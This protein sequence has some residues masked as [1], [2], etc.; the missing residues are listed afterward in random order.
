MTEQNE[1]LRHTGIWPFNLF[2]SIRN[3]SDPAINNVKI[4]DPVAL[5]FN[6]GGRLIEAGWVGLELMPTAF[7][8]RVVDAK[9]DDI[10]ALVS[11]WVGDHQAAIADIFEERLREYS[12]DDL[13]KR[14]M[15][16][17]LHAY[18]ASHFLSTVRTLM[19]EFERFGRMVARAD[20]SLPRNQKEAVTA[21]QGY[22]GE[23]PAGHYPPIE[24]LSTYHM[25]S[26]DL[27][28]RCL[29]QADAQNLGHGPNR[30]A[31]VHGLA[32]Y[33]DLRGATKMLSGVDFLLSA[34]NLA[35]AQNEAATMKPDAPS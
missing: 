27:F 34:V 14:A 2:P 7:L 32:S 26:E 17:A 25:I 18:R 5:A 22:L 23:L 9:P 35:M 16:E 19:P 21:I 13:A 11:D 30:H 4:F 33:G 12:F 28:A 6:A 10:G 31:E 3:R 20:G 29:T 1:E 15:S 8:W 24:S